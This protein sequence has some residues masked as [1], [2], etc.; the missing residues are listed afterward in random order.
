M[1]IS[2]LKAGRH[3]YSV[4]VVKS[5]NHKGA[6]LTNLKPKWAIEQSKNSFPIL[7]RHHYRKHINAVPALSIW[8]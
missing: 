3:D 2:Q 7:Y 6:P 1:S 5:E 4:G 8:C